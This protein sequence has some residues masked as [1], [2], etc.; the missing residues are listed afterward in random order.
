MF[1][2]YGDCDKPRTVSYLLAIIAAMMPAAK[3]FS[4]DDNAFS[5]A[6]V[7]FRADSFYLCTPVYLIFR[8]VILLSLSRLE[9]ATV[10]NA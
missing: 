7:T 6:A 2:V 3:L 8:N 10:Y 4:R 5:S 9:M 1:N